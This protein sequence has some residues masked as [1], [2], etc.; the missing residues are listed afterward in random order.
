MTIIVNKYSFL[1]QLTLVVLLM[2]VSVL[3][4]PALPSKEVKEDVQKLES[5]SGKI[6]KEE[7]EFIRAIEEKY[8]ITSAS[9]EKTDE[10]DSNTNL[11][12]PFP[13]VIAIEIVNDTLIDGKGK[14]TIDANLGYGYR[15]NNGYFYSQFGK[16]NNA[17]TG[18]FMIYPYSQE[19]IP[20][21]PGG[22]PADR[23]K[24]HTK[25][26]YTNKLKGE[27]TFVEIQPSK[28]YQLVPIENE[29]QE[30][31]QSSYTPS[32]VVSNLRSQYEHVQSVETPPPPQYANEDVYQQTQSESPRVL[33]STYNGG[34]LSGFSGNFPSVMP[35]YYV[36]PSK[37]LKHPQYQS[38]DVQQ[39]QE[40]ERFS[41]RRVIPVIILRIPSSQIQSPVA[42]LY[43]KLP[44]SNPYATNLNHM[45]LQSLVSQYL[46]NFQQQ[47]ETPPHQQQYVAP[48]TQHQYLAP[49]HTISYVQP[50]RP[51]YSAADLA[52]QQYTQAELARQQYYVSQQSSVP[53]EFGRLKYSQTDLARLQYSQSTQAPEPA[54]LGRIQ[55]VTQAPHASRLQYSVTQAPPE[56]SSYPGLQFS[57]TPAPQYSVSQSADQQYI[58]QGHSSYGPQQYSD[59]E[60]GQSYQYVQSGNGVP[61]SQM[62]LSHAYRGISQAQQ[63]HGYENSDDSQNLPISENYPDTAHTRVIVNPRYQHEQQAAQQQQNSLKS[64]QAERDYATATPV[65]AALSQSQLVRKNPYGYFTQP[66]QSVQIIHEEPSY[67]EEAH[68][69]QEQRAQAQ[70]Q[71]QAQAHTQ[72]TVAP[73]AVEEAQAKYDA[74]EPTKVAPHTLYN[75]HA[76][77]YPK[78]QIKVSDKARKV[79]IPSTRSRP[80][81]GD[82]KEVLPTRKVV[83]RSRRIR[84]GEYTNI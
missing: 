65:S 14:R 69:Q 31:T 27:K 70:A 79:P 24:Y 83:S 41:P 50:R 28:A 32:D 1:F 68:A 34:Q 78:R 6:T 71:A 3:G 80:E 4:V 40:E 61:S 62:T 81:F 39:N 5:N 58:Q 63:E 57:V 15:T 59:E 20:P 82:R 76:H 12:V 38:F 29:Q 52:R 66:Q 17:N 77:P 42:E 45:N 21:A 35:N 56:E 26:V 44:H 23:V 43:P 60:S 36:S 16:K 84:S 30:E 51:Q 19:D 7:K 33:Y 22:V 48:Q 10:V 9:D 75:Y 25:G 67:S 47:Y 13:A 64:G 18:K 55:Y 46:A 49:Q 72:A 8:N 37:F 11:K 53:T 73:A 54:H 74:P 2:A